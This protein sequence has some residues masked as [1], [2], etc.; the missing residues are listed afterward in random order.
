MSSKRVYSCQVPQSLITVSATGATVTVPVDLTDYVTAQFLIETNW[1]VLGPSDGIV[2]D[3]YPGFYDPTAKEII[4]S[5]NSASVANISNPTTDNQTCRSAFSINTD[6]Y[7][8]AI[9][10]VIQ[11]TCTNDMQLRVLGVN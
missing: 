11:V 1:G 6:I 3:L 10:L 7:P 2:V 9:K 8:S 4:Y 5:D